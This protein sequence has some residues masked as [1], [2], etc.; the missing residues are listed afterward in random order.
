MK[1][2][3]KLLRVLVA[4]ALGAAADIFTFTGAMGITGSRASAGLIGLAVA[5]T[6][7]FAA[8]KKLPLDRAACSRGLLILSGVATVLTLVALGRAGI[9]ATDPGRTA[10]SFIP[11][12]TWEVQHSCLTAYH[13]AGQAALSG[14]AGIYDNALYS[15][16]DDDPA[17]PRKARTL[18][19]FKIDVYEYPPPFLLL[20]QALHLLT[21]SFLDLR[22]LWFALNGA[23]VLLAIVIVAASLGPAPGTRALLLA[24]LVLLALPTTSTLQKGNVQMLVIAGSMMAMTLLARRR[25]LAGGAALAFGIVS[26]LYPGLLVVYLLARRQI[27]AVAWT[28]ALAIVFCLLSLATIG[29]GPFAA[30]LEHLPGLTSGEA[31]PAFRNPAAKAINLSIPGLVFKLGL[32]GVPGMAFGTAKV[33]GWVY[34]VIAGLAVV[35][36]GARTARGGDAPLVWLAILIVATLRSPFLP[37]AYG[38]FPALWLLTLIAARSAPSARA[39]LATLAAWLALSVYWPI[40]WPAD[41]RV[42]ALVFLIPQVVMIGLAVH[43]LRPLLVDDRGRLEWRLLSPARLRP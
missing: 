14:N 24:P 15:M 38:V 8:W 20:F 18:G 23:I 27:R 37:Q 9:Y 17:G 16:P 13:V 43:V 21:P 3:S 22:M 30:F 25:W 1:P 7:A 2:D 28:A 19:P 5:V 4:A 10:C 42:L 32:F 33:V 39:L 31:F 29:W 12:S 35:I 11:A 41:P 40:D 34:T 26:K 6:V 36:A